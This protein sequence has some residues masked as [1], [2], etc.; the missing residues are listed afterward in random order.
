MEGDQNETSVTV[1]WLPLSGICRRPYY[2]LVTHPYCHKRTITVTCLDPSSEP[3]LVLGKTIES[4]NAKM[5]SDRNTTLP[6]RLFDNRG[7]HPPRHTHTR[8]Q[9]PSGHTRCGGVL[10]DSY[11]DLKQGDSLG[12][13]LP[14]MDVPLFPSTRQTI[15]ISIQG[16]LRNTHTL[17]ETIR[18][19]GSGWQP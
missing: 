13:L 11:R 8:T 9:Q 4:S 10:I 5:Q 12:H 14:S 3:Q 15:D 19:P 1:E 18:D 2:A 6:E 7:E 17:V 16:T